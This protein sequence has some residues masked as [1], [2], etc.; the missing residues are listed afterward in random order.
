MIPFFTLHLSLPNDVGDDDHIDFDFV[1]E[2]K[3]RKIHHFIKRERKREKNWEPF[4]FFFGF[5]S[6]N[7]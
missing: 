1:D 2:K 6:K 3:K 5:F 4:E 7:V